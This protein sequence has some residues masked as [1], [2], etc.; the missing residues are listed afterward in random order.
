MENI[1]PDIKGEPEVVHVDH[2]KERRAGA[3]IFA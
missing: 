2:G 1:L 3:E